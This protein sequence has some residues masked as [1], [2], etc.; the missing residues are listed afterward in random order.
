MNSVR[1]MIPKKRNSIKKKRMPLQTFLKWNTTRGL[2]EEECTE[3]VLNILVSKDCMQYGSPSES[4]R[5]VKQK[6]LKFIQY[7]TD[8]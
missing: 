5:C 4:A 2:N 8:N 3:C 7:I 6:I 1:Q